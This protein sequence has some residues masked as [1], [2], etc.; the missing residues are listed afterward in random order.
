MARYSWKG[1]L[2]LSLVSVP[3]QAFNA[4]QSDEGKIQL[5]QL[6]DKDHSRIRYVKVCPQHGEI[7]TSEIVS[8][9]EVS[10]DEYVV[11]Q[12]SELDTLRTPAE[13]AITL[14]SFIAPESIDPVYFSGRSYYLTP[15][16]EG[17]VKPYAVLQQA[18]VKQNKWGIGQAVMFGREHLVL[19]RP[20]DGLLTLAQLNYAQAVRS[21][22]DFP[23]GQAK[24]SAT[25][26]KLAETLIKASTPKKVD[27]GDYQ[28]EYVHK[29]RM[30]IDAKVEGR[31]IVTPPGE[32]EPA[33]VNLMDALKASLEKANKRAAPA[34]AAKPAKKLAASHGSSAGKKRKTS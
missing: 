30:L 18:M 33:V 21:T 19:V 16:G 1:F 11:I 9:Y 8:G 23:I 26:L 5:H 22:G 27:L 32:E 14:D 13:K 12:P 6:H 7:P 4:V 20:L 3:V 31:E 29:L 10:K 24:V 25:E 2:R 17:G 15:D 28:D 34:R